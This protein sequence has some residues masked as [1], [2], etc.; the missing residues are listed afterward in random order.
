VGRAG[1]GPARRLSPHEAATHGCAHPIYRDRYQQTKTRI[2]KQR[3]A[4]VAEVDLARSLS[5]AIWQM[6]TREQP[7]APKG[8]EPVVQRHR[9]GAVD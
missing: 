2:G 7:F 3:G 5:E 9:A 6:L 4:K 1:S 8:A